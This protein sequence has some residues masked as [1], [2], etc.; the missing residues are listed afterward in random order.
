MTNKQ[1]QQLVDWNEDA[2]SKRRTSSAMPCNWIFL[3]KKMASGAELK[4]VQAQLGGSRSIL[5][6]R[7]H[8]HNFIL[9]KQ[10]VTSQL[11]SNIIVQWDEVS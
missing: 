3:K 6:I 5:Q 7:T 1:V 8:L 11:L 10:K 4:T 2:L 9:G